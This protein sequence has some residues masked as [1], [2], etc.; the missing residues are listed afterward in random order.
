MNNGFTSI[1]RLARQTRAVSL[2][3]LVAG[4]L[5]AGCGTVSADKVGGTYTPVGGGASATGV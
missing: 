1:A 2:P 3:L 4:A 5:A